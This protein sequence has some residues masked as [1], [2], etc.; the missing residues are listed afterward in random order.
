MSE[1]LLSVFES[2]RAKGLSGLTPDELR[3]ATRVIPLSI[4]A[5]MATQYP[6]DSHFVQYLV[7][8]D[9]HVEL[10]QARLNKSALPQLLAQGYTVDFHVMALDYDNPK[11]GP[12]TPAAVAEFDRLVYDLPIG[13]RPQWYYRTRG[14]ARLVWHLLDPLPVAEAEPRYRGMLK[15]MAD[16]GI[17]GDQRCVDWTRM[18][19]MPQVRREA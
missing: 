8:K 10:E 2:K 1:P 18:F 5:A 12:W 17:T 7:S 6:T 3:A 14:G 16:F 4:S 11:H 19:R 15:A 13:L 9:G